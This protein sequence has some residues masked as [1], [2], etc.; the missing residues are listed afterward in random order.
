MNV[1]Y[2]S[3]RARERAEPLTGGNGGAGAR[4][5][6]VG[7]EGGNSLRS[8]R[9]ARKWARRTGFPSLAS[10]LP[11]RDVRFAKSNLSLPFVG[12]LARVSLRAA[13]MQG[14]GPTI[15]RQ[16]KGAFNHIERVDRREKAGIS[17]QRASAIGTQR[18]GNA[19]KGTLTGNFYFLPRCWRTVTRGRGSFAAGSCRC[20]G[21]Q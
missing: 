1:N 2:S 5:L 4:S 11:R 12:L 17:I 9:S 19:R 21:M 14:G 8:P 3:C 16:E 7:R 20:A 18:H 6:E 15:K 10:Q 13:S